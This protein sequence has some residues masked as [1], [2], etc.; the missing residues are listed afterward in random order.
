[1]VEDTKGVVVLS[2][3][4]IAIVVKTGFVVSSSSSFSVVGS[5]GKSVSDD[6]DV[7]MIDSVVASETRVDSSSSLTVVASSEISSSVAAGSVGEVVTTAEATVVVTSS[8]GVT[9]GAKVVAS[10][11]VVCASIASVDVCR[12]NSTVTRETLTALGSVLVV[13]TVTTVVSG[14][15]VMLGTSVKIGGA[16]AVSSDADGHS[17]KMQGNVSTG[18]PTQF[19]PFFSGMT[20]ALSL[21]L[22]ASPQVAEH[23]PQSLHTDQRQSE[24]RMD[25][26][27]GGSVDVG[28]LVEVVESLSTQFLLS[29]PRVKLGG[30]VQT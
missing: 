13:L 11:D 3:S 23:R 22:N 20:T 1:M 25:T 7:V 29:G 19:P 6:S 8:S 4:G 21:F 27:I 10:S 2:S 30:H 18:S 12:S 28:A 26:I 24:G 14:V 17:T 15:S 16:V 9:C 5:T